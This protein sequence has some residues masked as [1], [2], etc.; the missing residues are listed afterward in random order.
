MLFRSVIRDEK[1]FR[2]AIDQNIP[3]LMLT[4]GEPHLL[5]FVFLFLSCESHTSTTNTAW[6]CTR[7]TLFSGGYMKSSARV[8]AD[9]IINL[10]QKNLIQ[11]GSQ[12]G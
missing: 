9:S 10:S 8:I 2:F 7:L 5:Y 12:L 3:L 11:L 6:I 1:V 4:S